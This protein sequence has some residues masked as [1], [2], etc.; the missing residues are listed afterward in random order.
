MPAQTKA[1]GSQNPEVDPIYLLTKLVELET[2]MLPLADAIVRLRETNEGTMRTKGMKEKMTMAEQNIQANKDA[3]LS[4]ERKIDEGF[5]SL[6][7]KQEESRT[8]LGRIQPI[9]NILAWLVTI[10]TPIIIGLL[11]NGKWAIG[12][13][14]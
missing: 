13:T 2:K 14:P 11:I 10:V 3:F 9:I 6:G 1:V 12:P 5:A 4:L 8:A 7:K